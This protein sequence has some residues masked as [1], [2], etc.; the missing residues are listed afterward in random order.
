MSF[1]EMNL[2]ENLLR[3]IY[4][5]GFE[6][7]SE[8]QKRSI[9]HFIT[10]RDVIA[11][12]QSGTGKT[13]AFSIGSL[14][15]IDE[16]IDKTQCII[17]SPTRELAEQTYLFIKEIS[18]YTKI[19]CEKVVGGT[20][21][22]DCQ[23]ALEKSPHVVIGTPGRITDM[24]RRNSLYTDGIKN[25]VVDEADEMLSQGF[26]DSIREIF[27]Y[28]PKNT[29]VYL[30]SATIP[31]EILDLSENFMNNPE[32]ILVKK[33]NLTLEG[34]SQYYINVKRHNWKLDTMIDIY[35]AIN[36]SQCIIYVNHKQRLIEIASKL[37]D[38]NY[39]VGCIH[40]D[41]RTQ[42]REEI[43]NSFRIGDIRILLSTD[44]LSRGIDVQ[45][46]SLV[47]NYDL[48][49][50][51]ET[52]IHR[53]GRSG[54]YGRKGVAINFITDR[55]INELEELIRFYDTKIEEMPQDIENIIQV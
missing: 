39:P 19:K 49:I 44:L 34:I 48:P 27:N 13:G 11:Q 42:E 26:I 8:I 28:I 43:I 36:I 45:Q 32:K 1:D 5:Y 15:N 6:Q 55:D 10:G 9:P 53:I 21:V 12:A 38:M 31:D 23:Q 16:E 37:N 14:N 7:P 51:K 20:N 50:N 33:E 30:F 52:Y 24:I 46:L 41:L 40:G 29:V 2:K 4:A 22:R 17:L 35:G 18:K 3:G 25:F 54:R 47:I